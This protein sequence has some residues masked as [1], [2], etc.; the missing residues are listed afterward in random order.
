MAAEKAGYQAVIIS[1]GGDPGVAPLREVLTIPVVPPGSSAKHICC[2][3]K[4]DTGYVFRGY[5]DSSMST[6]NINHFFKNHAVKALG[7][8]RSSKLV[9]KD[10]R[11][12]YN[13]AIL[14]SNVN[15][16]IKDTLMG[17]LR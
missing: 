15:E 2:A 17:H 8:N 3:R 9:F 16:E 5:R 10:L 14:D 1:C 12:S 13:E 11:D 4:P 7:D 6:R